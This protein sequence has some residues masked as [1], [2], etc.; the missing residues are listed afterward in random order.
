MPAN[1]ALGARAKVFVP[2]GVIPRDT[3]FPVLVGF[4]YRK[5]TDQRRLLRFGLMCS[6]IQASPLS[7]PAENIAATT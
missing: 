1:K 2:R 7:K 5:Y 4:E 6:A 3:V